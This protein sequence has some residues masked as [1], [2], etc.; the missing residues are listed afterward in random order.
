ML[1]SWLQFFSH[2]AVS[3]LLL[4][5]SIFVISFSAVEFPWIVVCRKPSGVL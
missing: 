4:T 5:R 3:D 2:A 1:L